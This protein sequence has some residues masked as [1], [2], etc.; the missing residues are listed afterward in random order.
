MIFNMKMSGLIRKAR[1]VA[2]G[3]TT[4]TPASVTYS[5]V[6]SRDSV[7]IAFLIAVLNDLDIMSADIG[8][9]YLNAPNKEK[10]WTIAGHEFGTDKGSVFI[11][12]RVLYGLKSA[13]AAWRTFFA[14]T[15]TQLEFKPTRGDSDVYIRPQSKPDGMRYYEM[16]LVYVDDILVLSHYTKPIIL[17]IAAQFRL[18]EDNLRAPG[19]YL[20]VTVKIYTDQDGCECWA[21]SS[22]DYVKAAVAEVVED[23]EK[24]SLKLKG[25]AFKPFESAY[26]P[27]LD[28]MEELDETGVTKIQG[29]IGTFRWMIE[30]GR[31]DI[32]TEVSQL[33]S[34]QA[35][36]RVGHLEACYV[37]FA[38][39][40]KHPTK[41]L[42]FHPSRIHIRL[43]RFQSNDWRDFYGNDKE[44]L[45]A[46]MPEPLGEAIEMTAF[47]DSDHAGN[48]ITRRSQTGYI[49]FCNQAPII[50]YS[51]R[52]NT[53]EASTLGAE[54]IA[55]RTCLE[56]VEALRF[57]LRMF[58][59]P[60]AG[61][62]DVMCDNNSVVIN[63]QQPE[64]VLSK[65][66]LSICFHRVREAVVRCVIRVGKIESTW[67]L[68]DLFTK[69]L[70]TAT[71]AYL[72]GG[73]VAMT[74][75]G[76]R[77]V[78]AND[79]HLNL[80]FERGYVS[81]YDIMTMGSATS[82]P[83]QKSRCGPGVAGFIFC[84]ILF[85]FS[86]HASPGPQGLFKSHRR[87]L[88]GG[89]LP[90]PRLTTHNGY[91]WHRGKHMR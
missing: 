28:V 70:P 49:L 37:I 86:S 7:R 21:T 35:M 45:P 85:F 79:S 8:N 20:G 38:Y 84:F 61:P 60:V 51:K 65:K 52:Q 57:K 50:W 55:A 42:V 81:S 78:E 67:N 82:C 83:I 30:L 15:L 62:T 44:E 43:D 63:A 58:G 69:S 77:D 68:A 53:V 54:F 1:L 25:K 66:H 3:Q 4:D 72:L 41:S 73:M 24:K 6:V 76:F 32:L 9:A 59:V 48:L 17:G 36:P 88:I 75:E 40:R 16:L 33:S 91:D 71:R 19:Q 46:D 56:A 14:Q 89:A 2:G 26:R 47:V 18:K 31:M 11:I 27:E 29:F 10:I 23:L 13:G 39:L 90:F 34:F 12:T 22:D 64:S 87:H 5:S 74:H 80:G